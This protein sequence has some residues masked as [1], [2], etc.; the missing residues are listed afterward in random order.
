MY[1]AVSL[2]D[3]LV[4]VKAPALASTVVYNMYHPV[5][6]EWGTLWWEPQAHRPCWVL[7]TSHDVGHD[8]TQYF[9]LPPE[10]LPTVIESLFLEGWTWLK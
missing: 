2:A 8:G 9:F 5:M 4:V 1:G 3:C 6:D 7:V 10:D